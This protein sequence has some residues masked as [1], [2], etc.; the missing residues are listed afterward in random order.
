MSVLDELPSPNP[1]RLAVR[2]AP[3]AL[4]HIRAGHPWVF[5]HSIESTSLPGSPGDL[6]VVFDSKRNFAGIGL[7]DPNS[8]I[9]IR[10]LHAGKPRAIDDEFW[11]ERIDATL[12]LRSGLIH[13]AATTGMRLVH[14]ENDLMPGFTVDRYDTTL[15]VKIYSEAWLPHLNDV[16]LVLLD[17]C[18]RAGLKIDR[19][20]TRASRQVRSVMPDLDGAV[21]LGDE[22]SE[23]VVFLENGLKFYVDVVRGQKTGHFLD[24]RDN[25]LMVRSFAGGRRV[26]DVFSSTGGFSVN[27][28]AGGATS[29]LS[30]DLSSS[31]LYLAKKNMALNAELPA[32]AECDHDIE[33]GDA[34]EELV[35]L[36]HGGRRFDLVIVDPPSFAQRE[37]DR[38]NALRAYRRLADLAMA[39]V[40]PRGLYLQ[41]SCSSRITMEELREAVLDAADATG[42]RVEIQSEHGHAVDHPIGFEQGAYLKTIVVRFE[43][44][45]ERG[46][47]G[48]R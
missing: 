33:I 35:R 5:D 22:P 37:A 38:P 3:R 30:V 11:A 44:R 34:F 8:P 28:A 16:L 27:A 2:V 12:A 36:A 10:M 39:L 26:L 32:V 48:R 41:S 13:S 6:A 9:R 42:R 29:V 1:Q 15:V 18:G 45:A 21:V 4:R 17:R 47:A 24:Q 7:W 31:A 23:P 25:R 14:G 20:V 19:V 46:D 40:A 43:P